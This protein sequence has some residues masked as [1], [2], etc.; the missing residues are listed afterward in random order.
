MTWITTHSGETFDFSAPALEAIHIRDIAQAL[1]QICRFTGHTR[2]FYSVAQH[3][4][5]VSHIVPPE[6]ALAG[7]LHDAQ[8]AYVGDMSTPLKMCVP[9][10]RVVEDRVWQA[11]A[12]R[13]GVDPVLPLEVKHADLVLLATERRDLLARDGRLWD[14]LDNIVPMMDRIDPWDPPQARARFLERYAAI[15]VQAYNARHAPAL[16][17][18]QAGALYRLFRKLFV[19]NE[20]C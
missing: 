10:F 19:S 9:D 5:L 18:P 3:S 13:F 4:V 15:A 11:V 17:D 8:E 20:G 12:T 2:A 1:S 14:S 16:A 7:L 6:Q